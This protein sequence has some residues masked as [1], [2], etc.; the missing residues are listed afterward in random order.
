MIIKK[1]ENAER[2][3]EVHATNKKWIIYNQCKY[4]F[5]PLLRRFILGVGR[6][7]ANLYSRFLKGF[8]L[9]AVKNW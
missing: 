5:A 3:Y 6:S 8:N 2:G 4:M 9:V 7:V 1:L